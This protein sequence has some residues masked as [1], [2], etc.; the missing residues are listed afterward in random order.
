VPGGYVVELSIK[1]DVVPPQENALIGF[2]FQVNNDENG[3][4]VRDS[5]A[6]WND[7]TGQSYM[8]TSRLGLLQFAK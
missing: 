1:L 4:G 7:P 2:D 5:V 6:I 8:N 3:D